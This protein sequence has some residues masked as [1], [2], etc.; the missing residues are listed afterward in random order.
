MCGAVLTG[1]EDDE[2]PYARSQRRVF[3]SK[4]RLDVGLGCSFVGQVAHALGDRDRFL[5]VVIGK[6]GIGHLL[7]EICVVVRRRVGVRRGRHDG[8]RGDA[9]KHQQSFHSVRVFQSCDQ[10]AARLRQYACVSGT[11]SAGVNDDVAPPTH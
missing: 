11:I 6:P 10:G 8:H 7:E 4:V 2:L 1:G 3:R 5:R 9:E